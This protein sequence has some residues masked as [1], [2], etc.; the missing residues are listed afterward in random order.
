MLCT[1]QKSAAALREE[2]F[3]TGVKGRSPKTKLKGE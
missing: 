1:N 3:A 2:R